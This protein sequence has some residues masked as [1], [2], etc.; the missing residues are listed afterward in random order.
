VRKREAFDDPVFLF[1]LKYDGWRALAYLED[2]CCELLS[3]KGN[4]LKSFE[5]LRAALACLG[6]N[7]VLDGEIVCL[8]AA[9]K[10]RFYELF[11]R[12]RDPIFYAFDCLCLDGED[13]SLRPT[14]ERKKILKDLV[15]DQPRILYANHIET[16]GLDLFKLV[17]EQDMEGIVCKHRLAPY[18]SE[19]TPWIK[20]L[21][22]AYSQRKGRREFFDRRR[23]VGVS[24]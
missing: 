16:H 3:R 18:G 4:A 7:A 10:P 20:V 8:D 14:T 12:E 22:P 17:C 9:G 15:H 1:E 13:L 21:N 11:R 2:G 19:S 6:H 5:S 24:G 23:R